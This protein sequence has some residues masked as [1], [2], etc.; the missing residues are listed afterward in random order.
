[1]IPRENNQLKPPGQSTGQSTGGPIS[2]TKLS[3]GGQREECES[4]NYT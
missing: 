1:M 2:P 4:M 3:H